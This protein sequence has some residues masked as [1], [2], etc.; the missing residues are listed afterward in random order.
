MGDFNH[1][2]KQW[3]TL[4]LN[5]SFEGRKCI[6]HQLENAKVVSEVL[7]PYISLKLKTNSTE[8][9]PYKERVPAQMLALQ[10]NGDSIDFLLHVVGGYIDELEIYS[11]DLAAISP[12]LIELDH[13]RYNI[14]S[15]P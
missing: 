14:F 1:I 12:E 4:L 15:K 9:F 3:L 8:K 11:T 7:T 10:S 6:L 13:I 5:Q 2:E